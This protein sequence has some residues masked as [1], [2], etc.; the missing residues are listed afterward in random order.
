MKK[1]NNLERFMKTY[2]YKSLQEKYKFDQYGVWII[3]VVTLIWFRLPK[4][5]TFNV[6]K[7]C[8]NGVPLSRKPLPKLKAF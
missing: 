3:R 2:G 4:S 8:A 6:W 7:K 5:V 1:E